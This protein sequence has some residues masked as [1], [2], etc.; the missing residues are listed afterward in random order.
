MAGEDEPAAPALAVGVGDLDQE[1]APGVDHQAGAGQLD[2]LLA[3]RE[4]DRDRAVRGRGG[5]VVAPAQLLDAEEKQ[6]EPPPSPAAKTVRT[7]FTASRM[8]G[9]GGSL[10]GI[11]YHFSF[12]ERV[13]EPSPRII[14]P[15]DISSM[16][17]AAEA[18]SIGVRM[19][20]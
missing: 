17:I 1:Q 3:R 13:P 5:G 16:S 6:V 4:R 10:N 7:S 18:A 15:P 14:R 19:N 12:I 9:A 2:P 11:E 20:A 8:R